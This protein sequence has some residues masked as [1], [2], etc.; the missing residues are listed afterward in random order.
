MKKQEQQAPEPEIAT[1]QSWKKY[2]RNEAGLLTNSQYKYNDDSSVNWRAMIKPEFIILNKE[3]R[4]DIESKYNTTLEDL[5]NKIQKG[6]IEESDVEDNYK[7]ILL[8][9]I[10]D[11]AKLRGYVFVHHDPT[12][13][14]PEFVSVRTTIKWIANYET[15]NKEVE[16]ESL[17]DAHIRNVKNFTVDFLSSVA[18]NR[19]FVRCVRNFLNVPIVGSDEA[20]EEKKKGSENSTPQVNEGTGPKAALK[21]KFE[22]LNQDFS[23]SWA[24]L[25]KYLG[26]DKA[27]NQD[28]Y[29]EESSTWDKIEDVPTEKCYDLIGI[30]AKIIERKIEDK[31]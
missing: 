3:K 27:K 17:A 20:G 24:T 7:M 26:S 12:V 10:K 30:I 18:E 15:D 23:I 31:N 28:E 11:L 19:G 1:P 6:L 21:K 22:K 2:K 25:K 29:I 4:A 9:G 16:F 8:A 14:S 5:Q 13:S